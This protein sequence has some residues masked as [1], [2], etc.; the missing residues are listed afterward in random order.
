MVDEELNKLFSGTNQIEVS[1]YVFNNTDGTIRWLIP[2]SAKHPTFLT[3]YNSSGFKAKLLKLIV[4]FLYVFRINRFVLKKQNF[5][6]AED[7]LISQQVALFRAE[8]FS[9]FTGTAGPNRKFLIE[10]NKKG[11]S[12]A[13][14]KIGFT[15]KS[16]TLIN[17]ER[18]M[19]TEL[20]KV[21]FQTFELPKL[22]HSGVNYATLSNCQPTQFKNATTITNLHLKFFSEF[23][24]A[25]AKWGNFSFNSIAENLKNIKDTYQN[26]QH[27]DIEKLGTIGQK[28]YVLYESIDLKQELYISQ[29]HMDFTPWNMYLSSD[30]LYIYDWELSKLNYPLFYDLF[31]F[32][33]QA[34]VLVKRSDFSTIKKAFFLL[35]QNNK[36]LTLVDTYKIDVSYNYKIYLL[37]NISYYINVY[38]NQKTPHIQVNWLINIWY[39][40]LEDILK[41]K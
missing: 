20:N 22:L 8:S 38:I 1:F 11:K 27:L 34:E 15:E 25:R 35:L 31:H 17:N 41:T 13:I 26:N 7:G 24:Q 30:K 19:L 33:F 36:I 18:L 16:M 28:L 2:I 3:F 21:N 4:R 12:I 5:L 14:M 39:E 29:A 32:V 9:V 23:Y 10:F 6:L 40:A 37:D